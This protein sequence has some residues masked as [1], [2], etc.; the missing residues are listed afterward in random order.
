MR[1][2]KIQHILILA[3]FFGLQACG[4]AKKMVQKADTHYAKGEYAFAGEI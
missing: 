3:L 4:G 1:K 2:Y